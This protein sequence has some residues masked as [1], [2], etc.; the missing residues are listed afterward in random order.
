MTNLRSQYRRLFEGRTSS[1][2]SS[3][4]REDVKFIDDPISAFFTGDLGTVEGYPVNSINL[5]Y[6][7]TSVNLDAYIEGLEDHY[8]DDFVIEYL[9]GTVDG[10]KGTPEYRDWIEEIEEMGYHSAKDIETALDRVEYTESGMNQDGEVST[11]AY[12]K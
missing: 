12:L 2:D 10:L 9:Q 11:E 4:L 1:N 8:G 7:G 3:L 5:H 6:F